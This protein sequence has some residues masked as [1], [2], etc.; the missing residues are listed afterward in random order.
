M[1]V[2]GLGAPTEADANLFDR[3]ITDIWPKIKETSVSGRTIIFVQS[4][5]NFVRIRNYFKRRYVSYASCCEFTKPGDVSRARSDFYHGRVKFLLV[6]ERFHYYRR[7][8]FRGARSIVWYGVPTCAHFYS[9][10]LSQLDP[11]AGAGTSSTA[12]TDTGKGG[13]DKTG[14]TT[15]S[16]TTSSS[17]SS[18]SSS[19]TSGITV[20]SLSSLMIYTKNEAMMLERVVGTETCATMITS[21]QTIHVAS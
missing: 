7:Y 21:A 20:G 19:G 17:S 2:E 5:F 6:T 15:S 13:K 8:H 16:S 4:Y 9:E 3:F 12:P 18:S 10:L 1:R 14:K 11:T